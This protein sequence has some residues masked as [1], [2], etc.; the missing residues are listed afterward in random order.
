LIR[1]NVFVQ[2]METDGVLEAPSVPV[3]LF[4]MSSSGL[5]HRESFG[6]ALYV[7]DGGK[8]QVLNWN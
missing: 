7:E 5:L 3:V 8:S 6:V 1:K 2:K 4:K